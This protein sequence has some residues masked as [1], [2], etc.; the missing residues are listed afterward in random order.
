MWVES[1]I[2]NLEMAIH[3]SKQGYQIQIVKQYNDKIY[4]QRQ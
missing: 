4:L 3:D 2:L 1:S